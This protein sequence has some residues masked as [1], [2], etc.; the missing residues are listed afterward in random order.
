MT[1]VLAAALGCAS[2]APVANVANNVVQ[3][4]DVRDCSM[5]ALE[6]LERLDVAI[7]IDRSLSTRRPSGLDIDGNGYTSTFR[8]NSTFD[9]GDSRLALMVDAVRDLLRDARGHDVRFSIIT[10]SGE[11]VDRLTQGTSLVGSGSESKLY[12]KLGPSTPEMEHV[13]ADVLSGGSRGTSVFHAGMRLGAH[14]LISSGDRGRRRIVLFMADSP[15]P[16]GMPPSGVSAKG[17]LIFRDSRMKTAAILARERNIVFHTFGLSPGAGQWRHEPIG[18]IAGAT[19]GNFHAVED[20][21]QLYCHLASSLAPPSAESD[22][23]KMF[24]RVRKERAAAEK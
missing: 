14:S 5:Q 3:D 12:S 23:E 4:S 15:R 11:G 6:K 13:L 24:A 17:N 9:R 19:G 1:A 21:A 8:R 2:P 18:Q 20:P 10:Y 7:V 22:W 16:T